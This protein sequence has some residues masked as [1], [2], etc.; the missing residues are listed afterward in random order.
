MDRLRLSL[1]LVRLRTNMANEFLPVIEAITQARNSGGG[2][3]TLAQVDALTDL[4]AELLSALRGMVYVATEYR[5]TISPGLPA[6]QTEQRAWSLVAKA[7]GA[8]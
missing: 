5:Q 3:P 4:A 2:K 7:E 8:P 1:Q 6:T